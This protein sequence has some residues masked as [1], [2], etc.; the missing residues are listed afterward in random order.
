MKQVLKRFLIAAALALATLTPA[1]AATPIK[2]TDDIAKQLARV[3]DYLDDIK[4]LHSQFLQL[5][6]SGEVA[7]GQIFLGKPNRLRIEYKPPS[8]ILIVANSS[9][10]SYVDKELKQIQHLPLD[11]TPAAFLLQEHLTFNDGTLTVTGFERA[12]NA[13][14][15]SVVKTEDPLAGEITLVFS[16]DPLVLR[17][18]SVVDAQGTVTTVTLINPRF[19]MPLPETNF[20][21][22]N[23]TFE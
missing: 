7:E 14:R 17:K 11:D 19:N 6:S 3:T 18:W 4:S 12:A 23:I 13:L 22:D 2:I 9:Y 8:P 1:V 10:L 21:A 16:D 15:V 20:N 5:S